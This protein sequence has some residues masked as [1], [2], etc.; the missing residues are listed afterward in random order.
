MKESVRRGTGGR[1]WRMGLTLIALAAALI[2]CGEGGASGD[3]SSSGEPQPGDPRFGSAGNVLVRDPIRNADGS[4]DELWIGFNDEAKWQGLVG[5]ADRLGEG[6]AP[7]VSGRVLVDEALPL[8]F[9]FDPNTTD[10]AEIVAEGR[11][12]SIHAIKTNP[13]E[14]AAN[15][16]VGHWAVAGLIERLV[17]S[18]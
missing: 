18:R 8:A 7:Y 4:V 12:T 5:L 1:S 13:A 10:A 17:P 15:E 3:A 6:S 14:F 11:Q 16:P 9:Y 2:G